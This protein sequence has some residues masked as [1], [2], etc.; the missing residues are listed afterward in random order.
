[1]AE[2]AAGNVAT[3][4]SSLSEIDA[5]VIWTVA[6]RPPEVVLSFQ[7][8]H[9]PTE[10][11]TE[12]TAIG[13]NVPAMPP[14][15]A[16]A[17]EWTP[18]P[19]AGTDFTVLPWKVKEFRLEE[20]S[21]NVDPASVGERT[22]DALVDHGAMILGTSDQISNHARTYEARRATRR[23]APQDAAPPIAPPQASEQTHYRTIILLGVPVEADPLP[24]AGE[25][26]GTVGRQ[27]ALTEWN[28]HSLGANTEMPGQVEIAAAAAAGASA[29]FV[30]TPN[31][32]PETAP[33]GLRIVRLVLPNL[34]EGDAKVRRLKKVL[35]EQIETH[36]LSS[37]VGAKET[38]VL[39]S[40]TVGANSFE[41]LRSNLALRMPEAII[42]ISKA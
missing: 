25:W 19:V 36:T 35:G 4:S 26:V 5:D 23:S 12:L 18:D 14:R 32:L 27:R 34:A 1:M 29:W 7:G 2:Q 38:A 10:L 41:M 30:D 37:L 24:G 3:T 28:E 31:P 15:P 16:N 8:L 13:W 21:W 33:A 39:V 11:W 40:A 20:G 17:I 22:L 9:E 42:R 6:S